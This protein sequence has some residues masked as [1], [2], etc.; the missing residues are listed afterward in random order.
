MLEAAR[1]GRVAEA[2]LAATTA[3]LGMARQLDRL[4]QSEGAIE[5]LRAGIAERPAAPVGASA[6][7]QPQLGQALERLDREA[8]AAAAYRTAIAEAGREDPLQI[9]AEA[10]RS[11][12]VP[13]G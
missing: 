2:A 1:Q 11:L 4:S 3:R 7:S 10:R 5:H 12:R 6:R 13:G 9:A 8:D